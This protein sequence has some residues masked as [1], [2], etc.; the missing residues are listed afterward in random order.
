MSDTREEARKKIEND[1]GRKP[2]ECSCSF[3][4][5]RCSKE[6]GIGTPQDIL[7]L[8]EA[9]HTDKVA[10]TWW[11]TAW[12]QG[13]HPEPI[14]M[15]QI[16]RKK[17]G[18]AFFKDGLCELHVSG[19][20]P[21]ECQLTHHALGMDSVHWDH[22]ISWNVAKTWLDSRNTEIIERILEKLSNDKGKIDFK[23][24]SED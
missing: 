19:L 6:V 9:G 21:T 23:R 13:K 8:I 14:Y 10:L 4:Q 3:C 20:K 11:A 17:H 22:N 7:A 2:T 16:K 1:T 18:C 24:V 5:S 12:A 15:V